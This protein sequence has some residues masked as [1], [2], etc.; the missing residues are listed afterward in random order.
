LLLPAEI[1][2]GGD[3][4]K[5]SSAPVWLK[6]GDVLNAHHGAGGAAAAADEWPQDELGDSNVA[7]LGDLEVRPQSCVFDALELHVALPIVMPLPLVNLGSLLHAL[8]LLC[9][10]RHPHT[11][12]MAD[13]ED[14]GVRLRCCHW[15]LAVHD[16]VLLTVLWFMLS[17]NQPMTSKRHTYRDSTG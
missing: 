7:D 11:T 3:Y 1:K 14:L 12:C 8:L 10:A 5:G 9:R 17:C 6:G 13:L 2:L 4:K 15:L 16:A